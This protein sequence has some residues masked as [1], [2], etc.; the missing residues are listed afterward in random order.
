MFLPRA[1][2]TAMDL[3]VNRDKMLALDQLIFFLFLHPATLAKLESQY[4][5]REKDILLEGVG[6]L[7]W[8]LGEEHATR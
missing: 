8:G 3:V 7:G 4:S 2:T 6:R 1:S 5:G